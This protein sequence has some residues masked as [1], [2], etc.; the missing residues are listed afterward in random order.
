MKIFDEK[1][2]LIVTV[3]NVVYGPASAVDLRIAVFDG[4]TGKIIKD[5][6]SLI[7]DLIAKSI[8]TTKGDIIAFT[9]SGTPVRLGV[10]ANTQVLTADSAEASGVK[11]AAGGAGNPKEISFFLPG[12]AYVDTNL[13]GI[14]VGENLDNET[15][16][17]V[18][19]YVVTAPTGASLIVDVD[20][21]GTTIFTN[22]ANR[23][24][25]AIGAN[26]DD[27]G[28]PDVTTLTAGD[29]LTWAIDQ[30]GSTVAGANLY[31]T[32]VMA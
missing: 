7:A 9:A 14:L 22:Q 10:G 26:A 19:I 3:P 6:G 12:D 24:E 32:I 8:G 31:V 4:T 23:P 21:N 25:I 20:K 15:I 17:K 29:R 13:G 11:W 27:S 5:G 18:K 16:S 30:I 1:G 28:A 2:Q